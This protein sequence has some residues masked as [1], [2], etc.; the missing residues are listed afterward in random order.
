MT[1][2]KITNH[3]LVIVTNIQLVKYLINLNRFLKNIIS[4]LRSMET[5]DMQSWREIMDM[6][7]YSS[8]R[9]TVIC[10]HNN[11]AMYG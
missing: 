1:Q 7:K 2:T 3:K 4:N 9:S 6:I 5:H 8:L 11:N 10:I